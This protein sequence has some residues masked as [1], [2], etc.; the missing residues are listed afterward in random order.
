M[1]RSSY[2]VTLFSSPRGRLVKRLLITAAAFGFVLS[3]VPADESPSDDPS[4]TEQRWEAQADDS[5]SSGPVVSASVARP[6]A[7][8]EEDSNDLSGMSSA[9]D[10]ASQVSGYQSAVLVVQQFA[11]AYGTLSAEGSP[12]DWVAGLPGAS[13]ALRAKLATS[14]EPTWATLADR[15]AAAVASV[16][17]HSVSPMSATEDND[18]LT[19][20]VL[21]AVEWRYGDAQQYGAASHV[22]T[23]S[24]SD[25]SANG[26]VVTA[27]H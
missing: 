16:V 13:E 15:D 20:S 14:T 17:P 9:P 2:R 11:Q 7:Q 18:T 3:L 26:W 22:V 6:F 12:G 8:P 10:T 19:F 27:V 4:P 1:S 25:D 23:V 24:R 21:L 5:E